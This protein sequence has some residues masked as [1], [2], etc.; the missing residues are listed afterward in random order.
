METGR[1]AC[2]N[3]GVL[4]TIVADVNPF[5]FSYSGIATIYAVKS[6]G[7]AIGIGIGSSFIVLVSFVW[8]IFVFDETST[9]AVRC[10]CCHILHDAGSF[11]N[12]LLQ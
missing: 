9:L 2:I 7:L 8:G 5:F 10:L 6:A 4:W 12:E 1:Q 3:T 11:W